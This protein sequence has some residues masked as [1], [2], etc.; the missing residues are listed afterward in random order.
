VCSLY[1]YGS[2]TS[3]KVPLTAVADM[4]TSLVTERI[5]R[6]EHF[7]TLS[8]HVYPATGVLPSE[9]LN[10]AMPALEQLER[11]L[12]P[13]YRIQLGGEEAKQTQ[14]FGNLATVLMISVAAIYTALLLQFRNAVKPFLVFAAT[15]YGIVGALIALAVTNTPFG[16]MAFLGI[17]SLIGV[18]ISHV[19]VLFDFIEE[20]HELG[21]PL[22]QALRDAGI[23]RLRPVLV[24]VAATILALFPLAI[25]GGPLWK[26]LCY[27]QIGG[28][29]VATLITLILVA[30]LYSICVL[31]IKIVQWNEPPEK[32]VEP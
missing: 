4:Q 3:S 20:M 30:V 23:A 7:R 17:A 9:V 12:P 8:V 2:Q 14:G 11:N 25:H 28:L 16:F 13:G 29:A 27:A 18:I 26:P 31:D 32:T 22:E 10:A 24:T 6:L 5:R 15:P 1:V 21:E 19:I